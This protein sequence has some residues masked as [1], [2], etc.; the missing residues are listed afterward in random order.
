[1]QK[2][3]FENYKNLTKKGLSKK[4]KEGLSP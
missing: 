1:M 2:Y 4:F 3:M